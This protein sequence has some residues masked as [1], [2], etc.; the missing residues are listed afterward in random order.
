MDEALVQE[1]NDRVRPADEVWHVGDV[2]MGNAVVTLETVRR[3]HGCKLLV[4]GNHDR[5]WPGNRRVGDWPQRYE[6]VGFT[7][8]PVL[9]TLELAGRS[10][11]VCHFPFHGDSHDPARLGQHRPADRGGWL[12][13]G[14]VH[15]RWRQNGRMINVGVDVWDYAPVAADALEELVRAGPACTD[16][17][18]RPVDP[19]TPALRPS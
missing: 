3:L 4:P 13:H 6:A 2:V 14:H 7:L 9:T 18:G 15:E 11:E 12:L 10:V 17:W 8:L 5:C 1:W 16:R 19:A